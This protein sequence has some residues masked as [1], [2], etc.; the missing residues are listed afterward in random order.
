MVWTQIRSFIKG[1]YQAASQQSP[2]SYEQYA[3]LPKARCRLD[4]DTRRLAYEVYL[5]YEEYLHD[6]GLWDDM[7][8]IVH[9]VGLIQLQKLEVGGPTVWYDRVYVDEVQDI[10]QAEIGLFFL[11]T[12]ENC[13]A[14]YLAG[15]TAQAVSQGVEFRFEEVRS[16]VHLI[17][18]GKQKIDRWEK[19]VHNYRSH[20]GIL[21]VANHVLLCL[22]H[23]FPLA[24]AKLPLDAGLVQGP[25]PGLLHANYD[26][27]SRLLEANQRLRVLV[28]DD[29]KEEIK[30][31]SGTSDLSSAIFGIREAKGLE[32]SDVVIVDFFAGIKDKKK[33]Q[34]AWKRLLVDEAKA[35]LQANKEG[36]ARTKDSLDVPLEMELELKLLYTGVT[37]GCNRVFFAESSETPGFSSLCRVLTENG[38]AVNMD[39]N[40]IIGGIDMKKIMTVDDWRCEG[41]EFASQAGS[42]DLTYS[43]DM[44]ERALSNFKKAGD[45]ALAE[46]AHAHLVAV[47]FEK[48]LSNQDFSNDDN[49]T[50]LYAEKAVNAATAYLHAGLVDGAAR[51]CKDY[52]NVIELNKLPERILKLSRL[53]SVND[54][55]DKPKN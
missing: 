49:Q 42:H 23:A 37:R 45:V 48:E 31:K 18:G 44:L 22:H 38:L 34:K 29:M 50:N 21:R 1:S 8:Q 32:F 12:G 5:T 43:V 3:D 19:L 53:S 41:I 26:Q 33:L 6:R 13:D 7:D 35:V 47:Q 39:M 16:V 15:D 51:I 40:N 28:R 4:G 17:S 14:L 52:C 54:S 36:K 30:S 2:L 25:R 46:R 24:A 20:K 27:V 9:I 55:G 10:T 11:L